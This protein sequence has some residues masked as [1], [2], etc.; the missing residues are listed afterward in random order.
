M[1]NGLAMLL[2]LN[3][4][5][6]WLSN[7]VCIH[8]FNQLDAGW[9]LLNYVWAICSTC[10]LQLA[11][12]CSNQNCGEL[13]ELAMST[14]LLDERQKL[15]YTAIKMAMDGAIFIAVYVMPFIDTCVI[16][17]FWTILVASEESGDV[18]RLLYSL[19][20]RGHFPGGTGLA[21][22]KIPPFWILLA[23]R[24]I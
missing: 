13:Y 16:Y 21:G 18:T 20:F 9:H 11:W 24:M 3:I 15:Q 12:F 10:L 14:C 4:S 19:C 23:L 1:W 22:T 7:T 6:T 8:E 5:I 17:L 2:S